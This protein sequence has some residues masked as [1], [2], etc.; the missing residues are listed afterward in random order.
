MYFFLFTV[1]NRMLNNKIFFVI[2]ILLSLYLISYIKI[3]RELR[4]VKNKTTLYMLESK[5]DR[6]L[7]L[8]TTG[9]LIVVFSVL[10]GITSKSLSHSTNLIESDCSVCKEGISS[11]L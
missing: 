6:V 2:G 10:S 3:K 1:V 5:R 7:F 4:T 8:G 9:I 11:S